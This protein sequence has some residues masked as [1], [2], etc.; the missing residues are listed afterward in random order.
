MRCQCQKDISKENAARIRLKYSGNPGADEKRRREMAMEIWENTSSLVPDDPPSLYLWRRKLAPLGQNWSVDMRRALLLHP[1][2][3]RRYSCLVSAIRTLDGSL[4]AVHRIFMLDDGTRADAKSVPERLRVDNAKLSLGTVTG[5]T[6]I[7]VGADP[8]ADVL[9]IAEGIETAH[10]F[11]MRLQLPCWSTVSSEGMKAVRIPKTIR[12][13]L[14]GF[15]VDPDKVVRG[16]DVGN[17][18]LKAAVALRE[19]LIVEAKKDGRPFAV[20]LH[21]PPYGFGDWCE[22]VEKVMAAG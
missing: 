2:T 5:G 11:Q 20:E 12:R 1:Q 4:S 21:S 7:R 6:A 9:G 19:R 14:I 13:V 8:N 17:A 10:A 22:W 18:G 3:K 15:D 16:R